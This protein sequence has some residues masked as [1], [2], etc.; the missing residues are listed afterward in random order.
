MA[1]AA[2]RLGVTGTVVTLAWV[3]GRSPVV[4]PILRT[5]SIEHVREDLA[6]LELR[7]EDLDDIAA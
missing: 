6:A 7:L 2:K 4:H 1:G 5:L 3:L